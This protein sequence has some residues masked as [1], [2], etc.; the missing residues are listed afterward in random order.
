MGETP[1]EF[2]E[3]CVDKTGEK[4]NCRAG[5]T[6]FW[7]TWDGK[8]TPCGMMITPSVEIKDF[9]SAWQY[10]R[11]EREK[12]MLPSECKNCSLRKIC[13]VC[14]AVTFAET[15][16]Y[17]GVPTYA[18]AKAKAYNRLCREELGMRSEE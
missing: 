11:T 10:I 6:V 1:E 7:V 2:G 5:S 18:C 3:I 16:R 9:N 13:D 4:I 15:G 14:A 12:I 8:M 17:D